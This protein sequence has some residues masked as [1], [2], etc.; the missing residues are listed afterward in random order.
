MWNVCMLRLRITSESRLQ[1]HRGE[2]G[3]LLYRRMVNKDP[4]KRF[5][6]HVLNLMQMRG[7]HW[8]VFLIGIK[9]VQMFE[10]TVVQQRK[11]KF[12]ALLFWRKLF[13]FSEDVASWKSIWLWGQF[14]VKLVYNHGK[15]DVDHCLLRCVYLLLL[16]NYWDIHGLLSFQGHRVSIGNII[17]LTKPPQFMARTLAVDEKWQVLEVKCD[18]R[19]KFVLVHYGKCA[20]KL[21]RISPAPISPAPVMSPFLN[22]YCLSL[23]LT[24]LI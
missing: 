22:L 24:T 5:I 11:K 23:S 20:W 13:N 3:H 18:A 6:P 7:N 1:S 15:R 4:F 12:F 9:S 16:L 2:N 21:R 10:P 17:W 8:E 19:A 14:T